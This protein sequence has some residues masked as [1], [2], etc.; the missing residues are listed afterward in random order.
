MVDGTVSAALLSSKVTRFYD[1]ENYVFTQGGIVRR[2]DSDTWT[3]AGSP[4]TDSIT[5]TTSNQ[6]NNSP[7]SAGFSRSSLDFGHPTNA[8]DS[9]VPTSVGS[10]NSNADTGLST[11]AKLGIGIGVSLGILLIIGVAIV[12]F[13]I[14]KRKEQLAQ[15]PMNQDHSLEGAVLDDQLRQSESA[16]LDARPKRR[17]PAELPG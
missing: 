14:G 12:A 6:S 16:E 13:I 1:K 7:T 17:G 5:S 2:A 4:I 15:G 10:V 8:Q 3:D 11:N 9:S